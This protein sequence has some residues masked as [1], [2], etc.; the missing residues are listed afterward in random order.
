MRNELI[1]FILILTLSLSLFTVNTSIA[2]GGGSC[3]GED[4]KQCLTVVFG[5]AAVLLVGVYLIS[6]YNRDDKSN[7]PDKQSLQK[8]S[9]PTK[10]DI[11]HLEEKLVTMPTIPIDARIMQN[12]DII[13]WKW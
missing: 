6:R 11:P 9:L 5:T 4:E 12:G 10:Y 13:M 7:T 2:G 3:S 8:S 1:I